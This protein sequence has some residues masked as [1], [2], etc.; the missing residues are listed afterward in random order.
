MISWEEFGPFW[1]L[2]GILDHRKNILS[3][4]RLARFV[5]LHPLLHPIALVIELSGTPVIKESEKVC[6]IQIVPEAYLVEKSI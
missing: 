6:T 1:L 2:S 4:S 5:S 3:L